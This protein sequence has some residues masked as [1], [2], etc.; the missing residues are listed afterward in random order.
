MKTQGGTFT[1][2]GQQQ[3]VSIALPI[4]YEIR[5]VNED[6]GGPPASAMA[7]A[8]DFIGSGNFA[9][10]SGPGTISLLVMALGSA[11]WLRYRRSRI[12][13]RSSIHSE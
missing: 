5:F 9:A 11:G 8:G 12:E 1:E 2:T 7:L 10:V 3:N 6:S 13:T 4:A